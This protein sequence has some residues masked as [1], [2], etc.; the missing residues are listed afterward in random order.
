M[1][2]SPDIES[3][4]FI[5]NGTQ[6]TYAFTFT[7]ITPAEVEVELD[8]VSQ[9]AGFTIALADV[10]GTV[11]FATAPATGVQ[12]TLRSSPDYLQDSIFENEGAYNLATVNT[13]NRRAAVR[14][15]VAKKR[16]DTLAAV[17]KGD[18]G[19]A[20]ILSVGILT[21]IAPGGAPT[22]SITGTPPHQLLNL[23]VVTGDVG[24]T[25]P[26]GFPGYTSADTWAHLTA[27]TPSGGA[28]ST[29]FAL[30]PDTGTHT[31][32]N[33]LTNVPNIGQF[34][35]QASPPGWI[36]IGA[37]TSPDASGPDAYSSLPGYVGPDF[38]MGEAA[39]A[40]G[41]VA[42]QFGTQ[43]AC[44]LVAAASGWL[45]IIDV[46]IFS[47]G[48]GLLV[49]RVTTPG[50][51][52]GVVKTHRVVLTSASVGGTGVRTLSAN[53][54]FPNNIFVP[55]GATIYIG[56]DAVGATAEVGRTNSGAGSTKITAAA[57]NQS[58]AITVAADT[59]RVPFQVTLS[60]NKVTASSVIT[61]MPNQIAAL[62]DAISDAILSP[63]GSYGV[64]GSSA[65]YG[66]QAFST[67]VSNNM[68]FVCAG[69]YQ[70]FWY[71]GVAAGTVDIE[72]WRPAAGGGYARIKSATVTVA[73][74]CVLFGDASAFGRGEVGD[75]EVVSPSG[76]T[77]GR[78]ATRSTTLGTSGLDGYSFANTNNGKGALPIALDR[79]LAMVGVVLRKRTASE[80]VSLRNYGET[81]VAKTN[82]PGTSMP[83][84]YVAGGGAGISYNDGVV[85][86]PGSLD[87]TSFVAYGQYS[88]A[89]RKT[90]SGVF[91]MTSATAQLF[92]G[93]QP[94]G[95][96]LLPQ[97]GTLA[98]LD[99]SAGASAAVLRLRAN[100]W[101]GPTLS[102]P[103]LAG[104]ELVPVAF[105]ETIAA[106][107]SYSWELTCDRGL[108]EFRVWNSVT[109]AGASISG[110]Y[111]QPGGAHGGWMN[112]RP[113]VGGLG[114][115]AGKIKKFRYAIGHR[116]DPDT[117][118]YCDSNGQ[119]E[120]YMGQLHGYTWANQITDRIGRHRAINM[121]RSGA[122]AGSLLACAAT[123]ITLFTARKATILAIGT[124]DTS[125][126]QWRLD[127]LALIDL[128]IAK[129]NQETLILA[130]YP[131]N[132]TKSAAITAAQNADIRGAYFY[133]QRAASFP[134]GHIP[135]VNV[136][137]AVAAGNIPDG[138]WYLPF[139]E[140]LL[141]A[142]KP[143]YDRW[144]QQYQVDAPWIFPAEF[145]TS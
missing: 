58:A 112:G 53:T 21:K 137:T 40:A 126:A 103:A 86:T 87:Y 32:S 31:D 82:F 59:Y 46:P 39:T 138:S 143:G 13:I 118:I 37:G 68:P 49:I 136:D 1:A 108:V 94:Q 100:G 96:N 51:G 14:S 29:G 142:V 77:P 17:A 90:L 45:K 140:D 129:G 72:I 95:G 25:G 11:T 10:G 57:T 92:V 22:A 26:T 117:I 128:L 35:Y 4:P 74:G 132:T 27:I 73:V 123:D 130:T 75:I 36:R 102:N 6:T 141:H 122:T 38:T 145:R 99:A 84:G 116:A 9:S 91:E 71:K 133:S 47:L 105:P 23:G 101:S 41:N 97:L 127:M 3:G 139:T 98:M 64:A 20:N 28:G 80:V 134:A 48:N 43:Y 119:G 56:G 34:S 106:G 85:V 66:D 63:V 61:P 30:G 33:G 78:V 8:G 135:Y 62:N 124:N 109:G 115:G 107:G 7:A 81:L 114:A 16:F 88:N 93:T 12:V 67:P 60:A 42:Q 144:R 131:Y 55:Q 120:T 5:G 113:L 125:Q 2:I 104:P 50:P 79:Q 24:A 54:H 89:D 15:L 65:T 83:A 110:T 19:P 70:G 69:N 44:A 111:G 121:S 76:P 18:P 52:V